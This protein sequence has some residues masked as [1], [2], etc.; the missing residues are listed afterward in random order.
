MIL[1]GLMSNEN[2]RATRRIQTNVT[3]YI[4]G[5]VLQQAT[6]KESLK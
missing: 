4:T 3:K 1:S 5:S 6:D 2:S